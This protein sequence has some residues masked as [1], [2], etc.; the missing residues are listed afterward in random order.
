MMGSPWVAG[1]LLL[2]AWNGAAVPPPGS[3]PLRCPCA[4]AALCRPITSS[5]E[6]NSSSRAII[7]NSTLSD[8]VFAYFVFGAAGMDTAFS[9][10]DWGVVTTVAAI[11]APPA[12]LVCA[13]HAHGRRVV[14]SVSPQRSSWFHFDLA[15]QLQNVSA[16]RR[17][18][19][20]LADYA[21]EH[22][23]DG[24]NLDI[25]DNLPVNRAALTTLTA[26]VAAAFP[27]NAQISF[28][29][30]VDT[31]K[32]NGATTNFDYPG[33]AEHCSFFFIMACQ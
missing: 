20:S 30:R 14:I 25:E 12:A 2:L 26:E 21:K 8:E 27:P 18:A 13:A 16:R 4:S 32:F 7:S 15:Q 10:V 22:F 6:G 3:S 24:V 23:L 11:H 29:T 5:A 33:L 9:N 19:A 31:K 1:Y 28:A 17:W